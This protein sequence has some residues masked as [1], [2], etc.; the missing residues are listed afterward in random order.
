MA[1]FYYQALE[2]NGRKTKGMI[3]A[4]SARHAR[5]LLRGKE[6][7]P[8]HIEARMNTSS[9]GNVAA[10][11]ARTSSR[12]GGRSLRCSRANWQRWYR[13]QCR[14]KPAYR[15]SVSKVKNCM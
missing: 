1:L 6:L 13:Q 8:V 9:G 12:G 11:A 15:R 5:Q 14:W 3:E 7:I 4:D 2:R 10:S